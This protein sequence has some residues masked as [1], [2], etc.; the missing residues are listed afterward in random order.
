MILKGVE[1]ENLDEI[2]TKALTF[3]FHPVG[4]TY[5]MSWTFK[6]HDFK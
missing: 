5:E 3:P 2:Q 6:Q 4:I 1:G